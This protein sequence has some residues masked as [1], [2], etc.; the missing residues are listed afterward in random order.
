MA[1]TSLTFMLV[2]GAGAALH[3]VHDELLVQLA[4]LD[5]FAGVI[6]QIGPRLIEHA[7]LRVGA[8]GR[9]F[10]AGVAENQIGINRD[11]PA[12]NGE[13]IQRPADVDAPIRLHGNLEGTQPVGFAPGPARDASLRLNAFAKCLVGALV[14]HKSRKLGFEN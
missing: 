3:D 6:D 12:G 11:G 4:V 8:R 10:H 14:S 13:I 7:Y 5:F 1:T 9:L 2:G